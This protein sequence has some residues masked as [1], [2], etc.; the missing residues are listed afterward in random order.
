[1]DFKEKL[2]EELKNDYFT[3]KIED[4][5]KTNEIVIKINKNKDLKNI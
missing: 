4:F 5:L 2:I 3:F 1:M